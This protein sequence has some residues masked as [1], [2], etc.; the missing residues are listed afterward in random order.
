MKKIYQNFDKM[1]VTFQCAIP[2]Y[3]LETIKEAQQ[4]AKQS[5]SRNDVFIKLGTNQPYV[6]VAESG[7]KGGFTY[8]INT[9]NDGVI[10]AIRDSENEN[11]WNVKAS[12][13]S[14]MLALYGYEETKEKVLQFLV[15]DL[16]AIPP[17][18]M[19]APLERVSRFDFCIDFLAENNFVPD[20]KCFLAKNRSKKR[21]QG[22]IPN[23]NPLDFFIIDQGKD[24]QT[25]TIG[26]MPNRQIT[27]Y[28]KSREIKYSQ[29][30][31]WWNLWGLNPEEIKFDIWRVEIRLGKKELNKW[32]IR[33]FKDFE[34][35]AG[36]AIIQALKEYR[37][38]IPNLNDQNRARWPL[39]P[40]WKECIK[41]A[42]NYLAKYICNAKRN[43]IIT[44]L[45]E[46][47]QQRYHTQLCGMMPGYAAINGYDISEIPTVLDLFRGKVL[48]TVRKNPKKFKMNYEKSEKKFNSLQPEIN[49]GE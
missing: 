22:N 23:I 37:Y 39:E 31:Y 2:R 14:L 5:E 38:I 35:K 16:K 19:G 45:R 46:E 30:G 20:P 4:E 17:E 12:I 9:G 1:E 41:A 13:S 29:K 26:M 32:N 25:I 47:M 6:A 40:F 10:W 49:S 21:Y 8:R 3:L 42:Q 15:E 18:D 28:N 33:R 44:I 48:D 11:G 7:M 24:I 27:I 34:R 36:D 43:E